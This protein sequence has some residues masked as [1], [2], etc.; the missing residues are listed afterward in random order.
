MYTKTNQKRELKV[1][2]KNQYFPEKKTLKML[3]INISGNCC[4]QLNYT[5]VF[6]VNGGK[7]FAN[8]AEPIFLI[9]LG[10]Q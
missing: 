9:W 8:F 2:M 10:N 1:I 7:Y 4:R 3:Y 6:W 5:I